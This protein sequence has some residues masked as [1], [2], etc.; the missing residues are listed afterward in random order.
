MSQEDGEVKK[1]KYFESN[2]GDGT[3]STDQHLHGLQLFIT[4][5]SLLLALFASALDQTIVSAILTEIA[6]DFNSF[7]KV[8]W[9]TT[10][11]MLPMACLTPSYGKIS[12][13][14]G[15]KYTM[16]AGL[17]F[18]IVGSLIAALAT[19]MDMFIGG[20]IIQGI[21]GGAISSMN[22]VIISE[23]TPIS[24]R[25]LAMA[26]IGVV[27]SIASAAGPFISGSLATK[28]S[29]R[30]CFWIN[31]PIAGVGFVALLVVFRPPRPQGNIREKLLKID[32]IGT[33][34]ITSGL[35]L[36]L[37]ALTFG[38][39]EFPWKSAAV[40]CCFVLG[41]ILLVLFGY[42]NFSISSHPLIL[43]EI[44]VVPQIVTACVAGFL[45]FGQ[46]MINN[47]YIAIYFQVIHND[48][49]WQS[50]L[51]LLPFIV[52][53]SLAAVFNGVFIKF[54]RTVK[55]TFMIC[56]MTAL[57]GSGLLLLFGLELSRGTHYGVLIVNGISAG[58]SFQ[59][60][61]LSAQL[62]APNTVTGSLIVTT[63]LNY[64]AKSIGGVLAVSI[65]QVILQ[66]SF[67]A[68]VKDLISSLD[69]DSTD[70]KILTSIPTKA[71]VSNPSL[72]NKFPD[73]LKKSTL[74]AFLHALKNIFYFSIAISALLVIITVFTTNKRIP[75]DEDVQKSKDVKK[76]DEKP[77]E[78]KLVEESPELE[79]A[80]TTSD[81]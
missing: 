30:W 17:A 31:L 29:W 33:F 34:L 55:I 54:S 7:D 71:L 76:S 32:Y 44:I 51:N 4:L 25:A 59:C 35:V 81:K 75:K 46:F 23:I 78:E 5:V 48:S 47:V 53:V 61:L 45:S 43:K 52:T 11:Y 28:V 65:S 77:V 2:A 57:V 70:Y 60:S 38:G 63:A 41:G 66:V 79:E 40:I 58:F 56:A 74:T 27:F 72:I 68:Y 16:L 22:V 49:A 69:V 18:F 13:A 21:G 42:Y 9:L 19:S 1:E 67:T 62:K 6:T 37:L 36:V 20:R 3:H 80:S 8:G 64:F 10:A 26:L 39:N 24:I 14:L 73:S 15:R 50:G 12:I